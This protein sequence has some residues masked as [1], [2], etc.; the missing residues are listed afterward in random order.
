MIIGCDRNRL[1]GSSVLAN[2]IRGYLRATTTPP[3][4]VSPCCH[5]I[6]A[7]GFPS[8]PEGPTH[9]RIATTATESVA[10]PPGAKPP[11][12]VLNECAAHQNFS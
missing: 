3:L 8:L 10:H 12:N 5:H 7:V 4:L 11:H 2:I 6:P 9:C 1:C